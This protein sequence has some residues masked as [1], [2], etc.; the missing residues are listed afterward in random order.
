M[1]CHVL[2]TCRWSRDGR[3][4]M[5]S[6]HLAH[7]RPRAMPRAVSHTISAAMSKAVC[8]GRSG[9]EAWRVIDFET[10]GRL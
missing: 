10:L 5:C 7:R 3:V 6:G 4:R 8:V 9:G 2:G 1:N